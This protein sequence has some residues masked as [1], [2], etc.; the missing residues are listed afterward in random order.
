M[1]STLMTPFQT[2]LSSKKKKKGTSDTI[3]F[4]SQL[5]VATHNHFFGTHKMLHCEWKQVKESL[6]AL[7]T[8]SQMNY[9]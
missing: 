8:F 9:G 4:S 2:S 7:F 6:R 1:W 5:I 3:F